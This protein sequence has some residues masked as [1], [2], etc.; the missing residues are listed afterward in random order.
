MATVGHRTSRLTLTKVRNAKEIARILGFVPQRL[1]DS[2]LRA[3][4]ED[5]ARPIV[6]AAKANL[7]GVDTGALRD[8]IGSI[9]RVTPARSRVAAYIGPRKGPE[10]NL[11]NAST[12]KRVRVPV[13]YAH[14]VEFGTAPHIVVKRGFRRDGTYFERRAEHPGTAARPFL[15]PAFEGSKSSVADALG[16]AIGKA[17]ELLAGGGT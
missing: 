1:I 16:N 10:Y 15:R 13:K 9:V 11:V 8:S 3:I 7:V 14:L 17:I 2:K 5:A 4:V 12:G 6:K